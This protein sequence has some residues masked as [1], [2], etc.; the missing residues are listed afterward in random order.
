M[1]TRVGFWPD[2]T[3][4]FVTPNHAWFWLQVGTAVGHEV[5]AR[6]V[7][8]ALVAT[9][10]DFAAFWTRVTLVMAYAKFAAIH[11]ACFPL[12]PVPSVNPGKYGAED[13][14]R[15]ALRGWREREQ[16]GRLAAGVLDGVRACRS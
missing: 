7:R 6:A 8:Q 10:C 1:H 13:R 11:E 3:C 14:E 15:A 4:V 9:R 5:A 12:L 16:A 2:N